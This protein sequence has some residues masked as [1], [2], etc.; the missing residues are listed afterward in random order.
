[1][2]RPDKSVHMLVP[3]LERKCRSRFGSRNYSAIVNL[4]V[5]ITQP[6]VNAVNKAVHIKTRDL[7]IGAMQFISRS[8]EHVKL[9]R[10]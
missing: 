4:P 2:L 9:E 3:H 6:V 8:R 10:L 5:M 7:T 1:M